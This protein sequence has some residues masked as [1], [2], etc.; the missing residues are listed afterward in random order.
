[1]IPCANHT[2]RVTYQGDICVSCLIEDRDRWRE[3]ALKAKEVLINNRR[4]FDHLGGRLKTEKLH[5]SYLPYYGLG[6]CAF[7]CRRDID[8]FFALYPPDEKEPK[9]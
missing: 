6:E 1:M 3:I 8:K 4:G 5:D 2:G 9:A 7:D